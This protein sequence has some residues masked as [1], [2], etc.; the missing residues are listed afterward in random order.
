M[1]ITFQFDLSH[2]PSLRTKRGHRFSVTAAV[3]SHDAR[4]LYTSGKEGSIIKWDLHTG[5]QVHTFHKCRVDK[6]KGKSRETGDLS[7]HSDEIWALAISPD[8]KYL[9]SGGKDRRVGVWDVEK[10]EWVK[11][12]GGH[13]DCISVR[14]SSFHHV[15][16]ITNTFTG[17]RVPESATLITDADAAVLRVLRPDIETLRSLDY[18]LR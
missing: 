6:G 12:F 18:G 5:R 4:W 15:C 16:N 17:P 14:H 3:A 2:T 10:N 9:A 13:R 1:L 7:G 11:G 8:G